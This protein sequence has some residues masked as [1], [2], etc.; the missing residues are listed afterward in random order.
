MGTGMEVTGKRNA[1]LVVPMSK[2][3]RLLITEALR[4]GSKSEDTAV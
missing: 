2:A 4:C 3:G 1:A